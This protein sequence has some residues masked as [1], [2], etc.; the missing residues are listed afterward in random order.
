MRSGRPRQP[1]PGGRR[2][3]PR[4]A[5]VAALLGLALLL[6][7]T[8]SMASTGS[9]DGASS[10]VSSSP[11]VVDGVTAVAEDG[12]QLVGEARLR[13]LFWSVYDSRLYTPSGDYER[14]IRPLRLEIEYLLNVK[15]RALVERT[16]DEWQAMGRT[17]PRQDS[18]LQR[19][20][21]LWP[22]IEA[23]DVLAL[24]IDEDDVATF[25][26]N[27]APIGRVDDPEFGEQFADIW[28][29]EECTR[30]A[31]RQALLGDVTGD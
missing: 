8:P 22:D 18:W 23:G 1:D 15:A 28:L 24:E 31:L 4:P 26:H 14:G 6:A 13:V 21:A 12:L 27:G 10:R 17:H 16:R 5:P 19:L 7:D 20:E 9:V 25:L 30:P 3:P 11:A 2:A 29:S